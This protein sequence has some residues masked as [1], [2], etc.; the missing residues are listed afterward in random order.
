[1]AALKPLIGY[2]SLLAEHKIGERFDVDGLLEAKGFLDSMP[3]T[4][5]DDR[6][7][8]IPG[9]VKQPEYLYFLTPWPGMSR[10]ARR[11]PLGVL[12]DLFDRAFEAAL[13]PAVAPP[14]TSL[15]DRLASPAEA[16]LAMAEIMSHAPDEARP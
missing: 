5:E 11:Y 3:S 4:A 10:H 16:E 8:G 9:S 1:M 12:I 7:V 14:I 2:S 15:E 13:R 6:A